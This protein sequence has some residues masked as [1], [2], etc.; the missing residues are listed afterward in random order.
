MAF[1]EAFINCLQQSG[2]TGG[3]SLPDDQQQIQS[4]IEGAQ[5]AVNGLRAGEKA[6]L[7]LLGGQW[8]VGDIAHQLGFSGS[9]HIADMLT[10]SNGWD[11][12]AILQYCQYCLGVAAEQAGQ[13]NEGGE[14][15]SE[16]PENQGG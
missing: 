2:V 15:E 4:I 1:L 10:Q 6:A 9:E 8:N 5:N 16:D 3:D 7:D 14:S 12:S 11:I 13:E